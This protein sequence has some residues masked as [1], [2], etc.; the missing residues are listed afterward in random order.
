MI[1][2]ALRKLAEGT[3]PSA[4]QVSNLAGLTSADLPSL[5]TGWIELAPE[6]RRAILGVAIQLAE[7]DVQLDFTTLFRLCL[8]DS[9]PAVRARASASLRPFS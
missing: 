9:D 7:D 3:G 4:V 6:R 5:R 1:E 2:E 8:N